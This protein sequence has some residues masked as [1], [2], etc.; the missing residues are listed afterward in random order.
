MRAPPSRTLTWPG[1]AE[2]TS[3]SPEYTVLGGLLPV[4]RSTTTGIVFIAIG[5][6]T[7]RA[8][9]PTPTMVAIRAPDSRGRPRTVR[10]RRT[11]P[12]IAST[13]GYIMK[14]SRKIIESSRSRLT[15]STVP[16]SVPNTTSHT[17][18]DTIAALHHEGWAA[19]RG[20][21][22]NG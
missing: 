19:T 18:V 10:S 20:A 9:A 7:S 17:T 6:P 14:G 3:P 15:E 5:T 12:E 2:S 1:E 8:H 11:R 13:S 16:T 22:R 21:S 4:T